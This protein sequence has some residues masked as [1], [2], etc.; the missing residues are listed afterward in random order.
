MKKETKIKFRL[1]E[2]TTADYTTYEIEV[3]VN[4]EIVPFKATRR[5]FLYLTGL[6]TNCTTDKIDGKIS[7]E[8]KSFV[9]NRQKLE[10]IE[11]RL[12]TDKTPI[13]IKISPEKSIGKDLAMALIHSKSS[14]K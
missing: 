4:G 13:S 9:V 11:Y 8:E 10:Y 12:S 5:E 6:H 2:I 14:S 7:S 3:D 1:N